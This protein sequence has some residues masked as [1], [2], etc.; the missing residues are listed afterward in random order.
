M[1]TWKVRNELG[2]ERPKSQERKGKLMRKLL[3]SGTAIS[4]GVLAGA[5]AACAAD[6]PMPWAYGFLTPAPSQPAGAATAPVNPPAPPDN[7][8]E[9]TI[10][11]S[12][13]TFTRAQ[14]ANR[15]G[16]ADWF[17]Q[18]HNP[19]PDI[20]AHGRESANPTI[21]ACS[22]CHQ[23][24]GKGRP[25]NA[26]VSG[27]PYNYIVEQLTEFRSGNRKTSDPRKANT[28]TMA[29][30]A[31]ALT[32]E[33][34]KQA[35]TWFSSTPFTPWVKVVESA[36]VPKARPQ[37]GLFIKLEGAEAGEE[38]IGDRI[39]EVPEDGHQT[40]YLRN[41]HSGYIAYVPPGSLKQGEA[42]VRNGITSGGGKVTPCTVCH[43]PDLHGLGPVP[44]LA[45]RSPSYIARQLYDMQHGNRVGAWTVLMAPVVSGLGSEDLLTAAAYVASL[46][47]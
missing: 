21:F 16:P 36:V 19:M 1:K 27:L 37:A 40:E 7:V 38:P 3:V 29:G 44:P 13:L 42:L 43:G 15:Y 33:E 35:A 32:D 22:L 10:P 6:V 8:T 30:F 41:P 39:I 5:M 23:T 31:K 20:I 24:N 9:L 34:I 12:S 2:R 47:P 25:E 26:G 17:P 45:G 14:L 11:G 46:Q 18:E 28:G 4:F